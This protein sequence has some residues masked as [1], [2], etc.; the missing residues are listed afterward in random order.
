[1]SVLVWPFG[2]NPFEIFVSFSLIEI[3]FAIQVQDIAK[4]LVL[5]AGD[6]MLHLANLARVFLVRGYDISLDKY[7]IYREVLLELVISISND[8]S[9]C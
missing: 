9:T 1:M 5:P 7:Y 6:I 3:L 4:S 8:S 2:S